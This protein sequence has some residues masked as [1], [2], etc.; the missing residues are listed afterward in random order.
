MD[1]WQTLQ[2]AIDEALAAERLAID[3]M[4]KDLADMV[5]RAK[6][7]EA[8]ALLKKFDARLSAIEAKLEALAEEQ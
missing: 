3:E 5:E 6:N 1:P 2:T 7:D 4:G 8:V